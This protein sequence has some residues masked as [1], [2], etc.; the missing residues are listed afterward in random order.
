MSPPSLLVVLKAVQDHL[1]THTG[2][3]WGL[4]KVPPDPTDLSG[5][6]P[7]PTK[8]GYGVLQ[9][10][11]GGTLSGP[12]YADLTAD[13]VF[14]VQAD[15]VGTQLDHAVWLADRAQ[16]A[17]LGRDDDGQSLTPL[18]V[19]GLKVMLIRQDSEGPPDSEEGL[20]LLPRRYAVHL[21]PADTGDAP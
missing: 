12:P 15:A 3:P 8:A 2:K 13:A 9:Y 5:N 11:P 20:V 19:P 7:A 4:G 6:R 14:I 21:T 10:V 17:L 1:E 16:G 18:T